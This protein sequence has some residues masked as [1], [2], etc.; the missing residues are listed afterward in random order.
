MDGSVGHPAE[1]IRWE[2]GSQSDCGGR[3]QLYST[4]S[5]KTSSLKREL[6][7]A[8]TMEQRG[9]CSAVNTR[10]LSPMLN[11]STF[12][13]QSVQWTRALLWGGGSGLLLGFLV[14]SSAFR[15]GPASYI[16]TVF[17]ALLGQ[18]PLVGMLLVALVLTGGMLLGRRRPLEGWIEGLAFVVSTL[19]AGLLLGG[20]IRLAAG[21]ETPKEVAKVYASSTASFLRIWLMLG[22]E[23]ILWGVTGLATGMVF[24]GLRLSRFQIGLVGAVVAVVGFAGTIFAQPYL[25]QFAFPGGI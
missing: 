21:P 16:G 18:P 3:T 12:S 6:L 25:L 24:N 7:P 22:A 1:I 5:T 14:G 2:I 13:W 11:H 17:V 19:I 15:W 20:L 8:R 23:L 4:S 10:F 9:V